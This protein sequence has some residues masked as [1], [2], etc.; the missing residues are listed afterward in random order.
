M[1]R[2]YGPDPDRRGSA[3]SRSFLPLALIT[4]GVVVLLSNFASSAISDRSR[5]GLIVFGLG[6]AFAVG[7][8]TTGR[9]GYA[10]PAGILMALGVHI[11]VASMDVAKG[12]SS[13][14]LFFVLLGLGFVLIY[15]IGLRPSSIWPLFPAAILVG[16]GVVLLGAA[17]LGPLASWSWIAT[18]WPAA[19]VLLGAWL[20]FRES[21]PPALRGPLAT[22]GGM[23]L[24]IYG[25]VAA[26]ASIAAAGNF[27]RAGVGPAA[28]VAP[29][30]DTKPLEAPLANGQTFT[31]T[32]TSGTTSIHASNSST[33]HVVAKR[34]FAFGGQPPDV[35]LAPDS[36]GALALT[37]PGVSRGRFPFGD[38]GSVDYTIEVPASAAVKA[39][40]ASGQLT[41][42]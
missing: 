24:L 18:F 42:E 36:S 23:A 3:L 17:S 16:L 35:Q 15:V 27:E 39:R 34:H 8:L 29:F 11:I 2:T 13:G 5:G 28:D 38:S 14:G 19:L 32:N 41:I 30:A 10:V 25:V 1:S 33:V 6:A 31:V 9:Y 12:A 4:V 7:R 37:A 26:A 21:V 22:L 40:S 20:L